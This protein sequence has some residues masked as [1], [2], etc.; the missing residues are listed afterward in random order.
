MSRHNP[1]YVTTQPSVC[2]GTTLGMSRHNPRYVTDAADDDKIL[3]RTDVRSGLTKPN[4]TSNSMSYPKHVR[5]ANVLGT[6]PVKVLLVTGATFACPSD[7]HTATGETRPSAA[8]VCIVS[9]LETVRDDQ[10]KGDVGRGVREVLRAL[11]F[12][13]LPP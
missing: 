2:H 10:I 5:I 6:D 8:G 12:P 3:E 13:L 7:A 9:S 4:T 11:P 1:R